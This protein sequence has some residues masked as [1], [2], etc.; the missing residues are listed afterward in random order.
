MNVQLRHNAKIDQLSLAGLL[1][2]Y[3]ILSRLALGQSRPESRPSGAI[4]VG[5]SAGETSCYMT[6]PRMPE[7]EN[8][9]VS[10]SYIDSRLGIFP[11]VALWKT[12][13]LVWFKNFREYSRP[14]IYGNLDYYSGHVVMLN[15][16][17]VRERFYFQGSYCQTFV[18]TDTVQLLLSSIDDFTSAVTKGQNYPG[19]EGLGATSIHV[20]TGSRCLFML[21][22]AEPFEASGGQFNTTRAKL[23]GSSTAPQPTGS[24][25][26]SYEQFRTIW[27]YIKN[28]V[29][30]L[31]PEDLAAVENLGVINTYWVNPKGRKWQLDSDSDPLFSSVLSSMLRDANSPAGFQN[32]CRC[33]ETSPSERRIEE[34]SLTRAVDSP[35]SF[36]IYMPETSGNECPVAT[37]VYTDYGGD[38]R[39]IPLVVVWRDGE[40]IWH[41][42]ANQ[43]AEFF[44][45]NGYSEISIRRSASKDRESVNSSGLYDDVYCWMKGPYCEARIP[46]AKIQAMITT[47]R[48]QS[49]FTG[50]VRR[51]C[52]WSD[53]WPLEEI[54]IHA[55]T[56]NVVLQS[57]HDPFATNDGMF[58]T[59]AGKMVPLN[60]KTPEELLAQEPED[61][62][63]LRQDWLAAKTALLDLIPPEDFPRRELGL[64][65][66]KRKACSL[67]DSTSPSLIPAPRRNH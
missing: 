1:L 33:F 49:V 29:F 34:A 51:S 57:Q 54:Q 5:A 44:D 62:Q 6:A 31:I 21:S 55:G 16:K 48:S 36:A 10:I 45:Y 4:S 12:G 23:H 30:D 9:V 15:G 3:T 60:G 46:A 56:S 19:T 50:A 11:V 7:G 66:F 61:Y 25:T 28:S 39:E 26:V 20:S 42:N 63:K 43:Y 67:D 18:S 58:I 13:R 35:T 27:D 59:A 22:Y 38:L 53:K 32:L 14:P 2:L 52:P 8:P 64:V 17:A 24:D 47:L 40:I 41:K 37:L 65:S